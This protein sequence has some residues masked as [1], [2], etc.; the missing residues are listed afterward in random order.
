V[1]QFRSFTR[2]VAEFVHTRGEDV[3]I[4]VDELDKIG[5]PEQASASSTRSRASSACRT[6]TS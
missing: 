3:F 1:E 6:S 2:Q 4:G 5:S